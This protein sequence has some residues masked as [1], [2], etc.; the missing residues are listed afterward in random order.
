MCNNID[1]ILYKL[2]GTKEHDIIFGIKNIY[3]KLETLQTEW[4][5]STKFTCPSG[6]GTCCHNFEPELFESEALYLAAWLLQNCSKKANDIANDKFVFNFDKTC[7][8]FEEN[9]PYHCTCYGGRAFICRLFGG[10]CF[11]GKDGKPRWKPCKFYPNDMLLARNPSIYHKEYTSEQMISV[12]GSLPPIM[13]DITAQS[14]GLTPENERTEPLR[15][16]LPKKI[17]HLI[18]ILDYNGN[19]FAS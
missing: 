3:E 15:T 13:S 1:E 5:E 19:K 18:T 8:L 9:T 4:Y 12:F 2:E 14:L 17:R 16:I 11:K 6:C 7:I 10:S